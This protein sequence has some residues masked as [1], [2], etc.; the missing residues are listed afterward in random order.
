LNKKGIGIISF[1]LTCL[2]LF[3][4]MAGAKDIQANDVKQ[5]DWSAPAINQMLKN[6]Y[7]HVDQNGRFWPHRAATRAE[8][9][10]TI[11][12]ALQLP[13]NASISLKATDLPTT[14]PQYQAI[15]KLVELGVMDNRTSLNPDSKVTRAQMAKMLSLSFDVVVDDKNEAKFADCGQRHWATNYIESLADAGVVHGKPNQKY[16]P[17]GH[18]T[19]AQL[20]AMVSRSLQFKAQIAKLEL[21]YDFLGKTYITTF[22]ENEA[23]VNETITLVNAERKKQGLPA[24]VH[25][26]YL[27]Q[28]ATIKIQDMFEHEYFTHKSPYYGHPWDMATIYEY[29]FT[30]FGENIARYLSSPREALKAWMASTPHRGNILKSTYTHLGVAVK[31][32]DNGKYYWVQLFSSK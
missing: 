21:A 25:D 31:K 32:D 4:P 13:L 5:T 28:L 8:V 1:L 30:S 26:P 22:K 23:W 9:A 14:H 15:R 20:A 7:M 10:E 12:S 18:V 2:L 27:D 6:G 16:D 11:V 19:R 29:E 3:P 24:L 17:N